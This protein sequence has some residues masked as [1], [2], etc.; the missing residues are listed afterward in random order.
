MKVVA[1][2]GSPKEKG[3]T[4]NGLYRISE[5]LEKEGIETEIIHVGNKAL[6]GCTAC[7]TCGKKK[8]ETCVIKNDEVNTWI[9]KMKEAD[10]IIL[11]SPVYYSGIAGG[12]KTFLDRAFYVGGANGGLFRHKV[13][14]GITVARR[15][16]E[17]VALEQ[18]NKYFLISEMMVPGSNYWNGI[19]GGRPGEVLEDLEGMQTMEILGE[20]MAWLLKLIELGKG[21]ITEPEKRQKIATN[22]IR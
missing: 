19:H 9:Q 6:S 16:G 11:G 5:I 17:T 1:F 8:D 20:N 2:N 4:Y 3:N 10:G 14:A 12:F 7:G 13:G 22:F 18:L 15:S 21:K